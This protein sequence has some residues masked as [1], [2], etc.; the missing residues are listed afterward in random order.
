MTTTTLGTLRTSLIASS[1]DLWPPVG[2]IRIEPATA[3]LRDQVDRPGGQGAHHAALGVDR[4]DEE[5]AARGGPGLLEPRR[6]PEGIAS[7]RGG[8]PKRQIR[9]EPVDDMDPAAHE[10]EDRGAVRDRALVRDEVARS[11]PLDER[12][13]Q[14]TCGAAPRELSHPVGGDRRQ[15]DGSVRA[16]S[17]EH[18]SELQSLAY[19]VCRLL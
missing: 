6:I 17:E 8:R 13:G 15:R 18:T 2:K 14:R 3:G 16:R 9:I 5:Q 4:R 7:L 19:L 11:E 1:S 10:Q 12:H